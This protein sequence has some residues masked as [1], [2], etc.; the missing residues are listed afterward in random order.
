MEHDGSMIS[1]LMQA[2]RI[3]SQSASQEV[4]GLLEA[5]VKDLGIA[6]VSITDLGD[7]LF[8]QAAKLYC[9]ANFGYDADSEKFRAAY[10]ALKDAMALS[11]DYRE[12][13][14]VDG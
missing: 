3:R 4:Q 8:K 10:A 1:E 13:G 7:P 6:G 9:K 11:G 2:L 12:G 14:G 5:C